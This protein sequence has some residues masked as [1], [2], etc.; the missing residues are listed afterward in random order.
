[1]AESKRY[2][3]LPRKGLLNEALRELHPGEARGLVESKKPYAPVTVKSM[4]AGGRDIRV[5]HSIV[6]NGPKLVELD[7]LA[8]G[9]L[10]RH[11]DVRRLP[12]IEYA[13]PLRNRKPSGHS[14]AFLRANFPSL[15]PTPKKPP[16]RIGSPAVTS[17]AV[18]IRVKEKKKGKWV[19]AGSGLM[20]TAFYSEDYGDESV[21]DDSG[22][23][24]LDLRGDTIKRLYI[25]KVWEWG[26]FQKDI[27]L[28]SSMVLKL[29][30]VSADFTDCVRHY[31]GY[32]QSRF[33][34]A[35]GV[36]VGVIDSGVGPHDDINVIGGCN[37]T[38]DP[39]EDYQ[40]DDAFPHGTFVAGLIGSRGVLFPKLRGL[41]PG[42]S[43]RSYR[44][45]GRVPEGKTINYAIVHAVLHAEAKQDDHSPC[46]ILNMS[47][48]DVNNDDMLQ[49]TITDAREHGMLVVV[50]AGNDN[51]GAVNYPAALPTVIA[52]SAM[53]CEGTFPHGAFDDVNVSRPPAD[54]GDPK[55]FIA[56]FSNI[57]DQISVTAL[58]VGVLSTLPGN[59][60][61]IC[62]GTS[63]AAPIVTGAAASLLSQRPDIYNMP[64]NRARSDAIEKLLL[65]NCVKRG[66]GPKFEGSGM[67]DPRKV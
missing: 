35:T 15:P 3:L 31:Y 62:S 47:I 56:A 60:F 32:G 6:A 50:S 66:F 38:G 7:D 2:I 13:R 16:A 19:S 45:F 42:V 41:A 58:G 40:D 59:S 33:N 1:M 39:D 12:V 23:A 67:P 22:T 44:V 57:G 26:A 11:P 4:L 14:P 46:D 20:V 24:T 30:P 9:E 54:T 10:D 29:E 48:E 65:D 37:T 21:T 52:V 53:G 17:P 5:I 49:E 43:I 8:A 64:R 51:R 63:F 25:P 18:S 55:E 36:T 34:P 27:P 28:K 61:G